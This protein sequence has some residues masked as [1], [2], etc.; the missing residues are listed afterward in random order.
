M[1]TPASALVGALAPGTTLFEYCIERVLG[2][3][4]FGITYLA[5]DTHLDKRVAIKEYLPNELAARAEDNTVTM[6][7]EDSREAFDWGRTNFVKEARVLARFSHPNLIQVHRFFEVN[8]TAYIVMEYA[9][10]TTLAAL[11]KRESILPQDRIRHILHPI[12]NGL[13]QVHQKGVLHRDIKPDNIILREDG[14]PVLIDFGAARQNMG[15]ATLSAMNVFTAG[16]APLEQYGATGAQGPWTDVYALAAVTYRMVSGKKPMDAVNRIGSSDPVTPAT[17]VGEGKYAPHF[18]AAIDWGLAVRSEDRPQNIADWRQA[19]DG[20]VMPPTG[21]APQPKPKPAPVALLTES[22][23]VE[24]D[25]DAPTAMIAKPAAA[26]AEAPPAEPVPPPIP[27]IV[28][29]PSSIKWVAPLGFVVLLAGGAAA[30]FLMKSPKEATPSSPAVTAPK[31]TQDST[32]TQT[33]AAT[34]P[35]TSATAQTKKAPEPTPAQKNL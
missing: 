14:S 12:L 26:S 15:S 11:L 17:V 3:G 33:Q 13:E 8:G 1:S 28:P 27:A 32:T 21:T 10:G 29:K 22:L 30:F 2:H 7:S 18:L 5:Q 4:G 16:Y 31:P 20:I 23:L 25:D 19:L 35:S 9:E 34:P 6:R 24:T